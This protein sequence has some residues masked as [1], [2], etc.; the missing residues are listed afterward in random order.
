MASRDRARHRWVKRPQTE[1]RAYPRA[2]VG[3]FPID[4]HLDTRRAVEVGRVVDL[5]L[6]GV[7]IRLGRYLEL[8]TRMEVEFDV[9]VADQSRQVELVTVRAMGA[10]VWIEPDEEEDGIEYELALK[11]ARLEPEAERAIAIATL[12]QLLYV[13]DNELT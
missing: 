13:A 2:R 1:R 12:Q 4:L 9:P 11:F 7:R 10:V 8:F 6:G 5:A 3:E